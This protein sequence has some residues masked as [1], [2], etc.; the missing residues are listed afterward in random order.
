VHG[1]L[2]GIDLRGDVYWSLIDN[3]EWIVGYRPTFDLIAVV[4]ALAGRGGHATAGA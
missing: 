1:C 4:L 2:A 3:F